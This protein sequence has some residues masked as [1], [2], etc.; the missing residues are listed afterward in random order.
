MDVPESLQRKIDLF[1]A[2]GR[3]FREGAELFATTSW[4]AV[5]L[6]QHIVPEDHEPAADALD[7]DKVAGALEQMRQGYLQVAAQLP[8]HGDFLRHT[9]A[10]L[11]NA[12]APPQPAEVSGEPSFSFASETPFNFSANPL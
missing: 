1:R 5:C 6:G 3:V 12:P 10:S 8:I 2:K 7:E 9:G 4:V 11:A